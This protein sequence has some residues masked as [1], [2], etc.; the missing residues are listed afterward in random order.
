MGEELDAN[1]KV[2]CKPAGD[3]LT[4]FLAATLDRSRASLVANQLVARYGDAGRALDKGLILIS[5]TGNG[6]VGFDHAR[7]IVQACAFDWYNDRISSHIAQQAWASLIPL[8]QH[9]RPSGCSVWEP[10]QRTVVFLNARGWLQLKMAWDSVA[11]PCFDA[12]RI[13]HQALNRR[14][15]YLFPVLK[16][17]LPSGRAICNL[18]MRAVDS[19][20]RAESAPSIELLDFI[21][22][23]EIPI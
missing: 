5:L 23:R 13:I 21:W 8:P 11:I 20:Q 10:V 17:T 15:D 4:G 6:T 16:S 9:Y 18:D 1:R 12:R 14:L 22:S 7:S 2:P 19:L 3:I